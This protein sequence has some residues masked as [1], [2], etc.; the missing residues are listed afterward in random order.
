MS[1]MLN[2]SAQHAI[3]L[4]AV[5]R[6]NAFSSNIRTGGTLACTCAMVVFWRS[7]HQQPIKSPNIHICLIFNCSRATVQY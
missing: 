3:S 2:Y 5:R 6:S 4:V 7:R 1:T